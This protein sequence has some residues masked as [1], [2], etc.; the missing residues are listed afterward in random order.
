MLLNLTLK[1][2]RQRLSRHLISGLSIVIASASLF[3]FLSFNS[4][5][6]SSTFKEL[7]NAI[8]LNQISVQPSLSEQGIVSFLNR[9][10]N[11]KLTSSHI[12]ELQ[13]IPGVNK[14]YGQTQLE[15]FA[16]LKTS[17]FGFTLNTDTM[18]FGLPA[19]FLAIDPQIWQSSEEPYPALIPRKF[20]DIY[21]F[22]IAI[23]QN[24][25]SFT[26]ENLI[27]KTLTLSPGSSI[28]FPITNNKFSDIKFKVVGF[29]DK[30][31][32]IGITVPS[33]LI[34]KL[35]QELL[36]KSS[37]TYLKLFVETASPSLTT[38]I[39]KQIETMGLNTDYLQKN[40]QSVQSKLIYIEK[41]LQIISL[42]I[43]LTAGIAILSTFLATISERK[44]EIGLLKALG[45][46]KNHLRT[47]I[48]QEA[49]IIGIIGSICGIAL[50]YGLSKILTTQITN[51]FSDLSVIPETIFL[52][53]PENII[54]T[55]LFGFGITLIAAL[56]P[57]IKASNVSPMENLRN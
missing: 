39:A 1:N 4:G 47:L 36:Q 16:S 40:F 57:A 6:S 41:A 9:N 21:N 42:I 35:N 7:E 50:G 31:D 11:N 24:L 37:D 51:R 53:T 45:A 34:E 23:P 3:T 8:P 22:T 38:Q 30:I 20:L 48:L 49:G 44:K 33:Q 15:T 25:P 14:V 10:Q 18:V 32:L 43:F 55:L 52:T 46:N 17:V 12:T 19:E 56:I 28:F 29:S 54:K 26:E 2:L 13:K 27:G 5:L